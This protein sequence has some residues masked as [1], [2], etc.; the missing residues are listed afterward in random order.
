MIVNHCSF[1]YEVFDV[2][3]KFEGYYAVGADEVFS[4]HASSYTSVATR[5]S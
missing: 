2:A 4:H 1:Q 3:A 5:K